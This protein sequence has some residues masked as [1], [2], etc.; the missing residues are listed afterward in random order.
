[1]EKR[2]SRIAKSLGRLRTRALGSLAHSKNKL[3][4]LTVIHVILVAVSQGLLCYALIWY[5]GLH[6][7]HLHSMHS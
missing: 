4:T 5:V 6:S 7:V 2:C 1:M 3:V